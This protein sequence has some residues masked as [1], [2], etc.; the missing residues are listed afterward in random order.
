[1]QTRMRGNRVGIELLAKGSDSKSLI[2]MPED[3][4]A[5]G[6]IRYVGDGVTAPELQVGVKV[7]YGKVHHQLRMNGANILVMN[8]DNVYA[9]VQEDTAK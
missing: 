3:T 4:S 9:V 6:V 5:V 1:M 7:Y 2:A 8:E